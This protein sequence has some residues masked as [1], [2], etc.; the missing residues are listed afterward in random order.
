MYCIVALGNPTEKLAK[1]RHNAG[2][3][4]LDYM[5]PNETYEHSKMAKADFAKTQFA[6][7]SIEL[8]KPQTF[9]N[10]SGISAAYAKKHHELDNAKFIVLHDE[11][12]LP[13]GQVKISYDRGD[14]GHNG[15]KSLNAHLGGSDYYRIRIGLAQ[16]YTE[17]KFIKPN[18]LGNFTEVEIKALH[19]VA[20]KVKQAIEILI[21][22]GYEKAATF[23]NG[24]NNV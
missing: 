7:T 16:R 1:T 6:G 12:D 20:P 11:V 10:E 17:G 9:M 19:D 24:S 3:L 14:A 21:T 5:F 2:W 15:I 23:L 13:L 8:I 4:L 22:A 18:V